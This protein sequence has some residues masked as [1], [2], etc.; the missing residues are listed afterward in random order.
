MRFSTLNKVAILT[1]SQMRHDY[2]RKSLALCD[3][4]EVVASYCEDGDLLRAMSEK[5][6]DSDAAIELAHLDARDR[7]EEDFFGK[8]V[9]LAPDLSNPTH[10]PR[11]AINEKETAQRIIDL[12]PD[13]LIAYG[14]SIV[15]PPL[16]SAFPGKFLNVHLGLSPYYRGAGTNFWPFVNREPEYA[17]L[18]YMYIDAGVDTGEIIHQVRPRIF[19]GDTIH[20]I[21]NR[22][23]SDMSAIY[24]DIIR[25]FDKLERLEQPPIPK[26]EKVYMKKHFSAEA[27]EKM[28]QN[29]ADGMIQDYLARKPERDSRVPIIKNPALMKVA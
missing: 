27:T 14:C 16:L 20:Q 11:G 22:L 9:A 26:D 2:F 10:V 13:L 7:S 29:F 5:K 3:G 6:N 4:I 24:A 21:G 8:F 28:Y 23:I 19:P 17:G 1:S 25:S 12:H 18:T 15:K